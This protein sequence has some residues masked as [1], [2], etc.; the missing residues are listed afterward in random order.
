MR[1]LRIILVWTLVSL[2]LQGGAY[3]LLNNKVQ[4]VMAPLSNEPITLK[5][6]ATIPGSNLKNIQI[7]YAKDYLAYTENGTLKVFNL[8]KGKQVFEK[9]SPSTTDKTLGVLTYQWLPD[10]N[11]LLYFYAKKNPNE[12]TTVTVYPKPTVQTPLR[13][14]LLKTKTEDPNQTI[15]KKFPKWFL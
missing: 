9:K 14:R 2:F 13:I 12:V 3:S 6:K 11:T 15:E 4:E 10:R 7:S 5:L 8:V 1:K